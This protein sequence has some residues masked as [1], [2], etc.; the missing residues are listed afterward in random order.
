M[1][2]RG[3]RESRPVRMAAL[4]VVVGA[5]AFVFLDGHAARSEDDI[6][7]IRAVPF[8][9]RGGES[10]LADLYLPP[11]RFARPVPTVLMIHGGAWMSGS[12]WNMVHHANAVARAGYAVVNIDYRLAPKHR[13]PA[14]INDCRAAWAWLCGHAPDHGFDRGR[15]AVYGYSAGGHLACLLGLGPLDESTESRPSGLPRPRAIVAGGAVCEFDWVAEQSGLVSYFL[16]GTRAEVPDAYRSAAPI[17]FVSPDDPPLF[18]FHG[19]AD[20]MVPVSSPRRL[21]SEVE[22]VG[23]QAVLRVLPD[24]GHVSTFFSDDPPREAVRFLDG[25]FSRDKRPEGSTH[26]PEPTGSN[27]APNGT[28]APEHEPNS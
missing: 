15:L 14:Q 13:H 20:R 2:T 22:R 4:L 27:A 7:R 6:Q 17:S 28:R 11:A 12:R 9:R 5:A 3:N 23:G 26:G 18:L 21:A 19:G 16:G 8:A 10:L 24:A 1:G 25:V